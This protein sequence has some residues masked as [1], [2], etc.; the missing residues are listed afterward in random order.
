MGGFS[1]YG[2]TTPGGNAFAAA[3]TSQGTGYTPE[4]SKPAQSMGGFQTAG[5]QYGLGPQAPIQYSVANNSGQLNVAAPTGGGPSTWGVGG[6]GQYMN[7]A[8][9]ALYRQATS[10]LDPQWA[11]TQADTDAKLANMGLVRGSDAWNREQQ[12][13]SQQRNDAYNQANFSAI[14]ATGQEAQRQQGMDIAAGQFGNVASKQDLD[15]QIARQQA[16]NAA[17]GQQ[18]QQDLSTGQ[19]ANE[20]QAQQNAQ[21]L[22][23]ANLN[24]SAMGTQLNAASSRYNADVSAQASG[25]AAMANSAANLRAAEIAADTARRGQDFSYAYQNRGLDL[26]EQMQNYNIATSMNSYP[27]QVQAN[28]MNGMVPN[29]P[30]ISAPATPGAPYSGSGAQYSSQVNQG[31]GNMYTGIGQATGGVFGAIGQYGNTNRSTQPIS[32]PGNPQGPG[33]FGGVSMGG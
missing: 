23:A 8:G 13:I 4:Y 25:A 29:V 12:N 5:F 22:A 11:Q 6:Q 19:F 24:N 18:Y 1:Y 27:G 3:N 20:A 17:L 26:T 15:A 30:N 7:Q 31:I 10:R 9:D 21:D 33:Y 2:Q 16:Q 14:Q 28:Y 32:T